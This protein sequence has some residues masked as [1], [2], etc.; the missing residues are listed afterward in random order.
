MCS[1]LCLYLESY[2]PTGEDDTSDFC[3]C[4][5][6][7]HI[8]PDIFFNFFFSRG[9]WGMDFLSDCSVR[10]PSNPVSW[11]VSKLFLLGYGFSLGLFRPHLYPTLFPGE[12]ASCSFLGYGFSPGLFCPHSY[13]TMFSGESA[14]CSFW[15]M[16]F[17]DLSRISVAPSLSCKYSLFYFQV[18]GGA[19]AGLGIQFGVEDLSRTFAEL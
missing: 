8:L 5:V 12:S 18:S 11:G 15:G 1:S 7:G 10:I 3:R 14:S 4:F 2:S 13:P 19:F 9:V 17:L 6:A 16:D